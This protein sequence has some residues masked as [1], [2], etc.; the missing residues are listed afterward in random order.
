MRQAA[1]YAIDRE[2]LCKSLLNGTCIPGIGSFIPAILVR[3]PQ[4]AL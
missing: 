2:G 3:Q 1:N 4:S